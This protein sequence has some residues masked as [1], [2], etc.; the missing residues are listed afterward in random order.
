MHVARPEL[1]VARPQVCLESMISWIR[2][3]DIMDSWPGL[4]WPGMV[5]W[6]GL[7]WPD[8]SCGLQKHEIIEKALVFL[9]FSEKVSILLGVVEGQSHRLRCLCIKMAGDPPARQPHSST[10][11]LPRPSEPLQLKPVRGTMSS[12]LDAVENH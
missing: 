8:G 11:P 6:P 12:H 1:H 5:S 3:H 9:T 4:A 10:G 7:A 2:I